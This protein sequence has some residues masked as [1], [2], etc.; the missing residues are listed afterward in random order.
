[1]FRYSYM[2][3]KDSVPQQDIAKPSMP[4]VGD[5]VILSKIGQGGIAEIFRALQISLQREVAIKVLSPKYNHD[6]EVVKRFE[7]EAILIA[8]LNHP[9]I[10]HV[11]DKGVHGNR[12]YFVMEY[13]DGTNFRTIINNPNI[14]LKVK[15]E[16]IISI[17]KALEFAHM[18]GVIHGDLKPAN[19]LVDRQGNA[20]IADFGIAQLR[21]Q[22]NATMESS[23]TIMGTFAYMSPEQKLSSANLTR[24]TDIYA[25]GVILYEICCREKPSEPFKLPS[26]INPTVPSSMDDIICRCLEQ[27]PADRFPIV[28]NLKD[29]L[30][31]AFS[32]QFFTSGPAETSIA[33]TEAFM[34][35]CRFL[36]TIKDDRFGATYL[37]EHKETKNLH[38]IKKKN[39]GDVGLREN[40][41]LTELKHKNILPVICAGSDTTKTIIVTDYAPGGSLAERPGRKYSWREALDITMQIAEGLRFAHDNDIIHGDLRPSNILFGENDTILLTDFGFPVHYAGQKDWYAPP[42]RKYSRQ[43]DMYSLGVIFYMLMTDK[44]AQHDISGNPY[45]LELEKKVTNKVCAILKRL[46]PTDPAKRYQ[47]LNDMLAE[48]AEAMEQKEPKPKTAK[49]S[50]PKKQEV[51]ILPIILIVLAI[52]TGILI[53]TCWDKLSQCLHLG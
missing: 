50:P 12:Y 4:R 30:M 48:G 10:I 26:E 40:E 3:N 27:N 29:A 19:I 42:E 46:L 5:Y 33:R 35:K 53:V 9:N 23:D 17:C 52:T 41:L 16:M 22:I 14:D 34:G 25:L 24:A 2:E 45:L 20:K 1:L 28:A 36:D 13:V 44:L 38:I 15:I 31:Y 8:R 21:D 7:M 51:N 39:K 32:G 43:G 18:N 11:I 49:P 37:V 6:P 47:S